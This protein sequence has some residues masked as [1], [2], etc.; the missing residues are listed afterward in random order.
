MPT[1]G[2]ETKAAHERDAIEK[3]IDQIRRYH[4]ETPEMMAALQL[5][6]VTV[7]G[8]RVLPTQRRI[9]RSQQLPEGN[10]TAPV[11]EWG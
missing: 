8:C 3:G 1:L 6:D 11:R 4:D 7:A 9:E 10:S 2:A 5:F